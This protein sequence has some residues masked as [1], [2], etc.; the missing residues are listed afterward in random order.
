MCTARNTQHLTC[1]S[2]SCKGLHTQSTFSSSRKGEAERWA[3]TEYGTH[4]VRRFR[5]YTVQNLSQWK[6]GWE[7]LSHTA[8][9]S[10]KQHNLVNSFASDESSMEERGRREPTNVWFVSPVMVFILHFILESPVL[11]L[12]QF[13]HHGQHLRYWNRWKTQVKI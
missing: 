7:S 11:I 8:E 10:V 5:P 3:T 13:H 4:I 2:S 12:L 6:P 9:L 1:T